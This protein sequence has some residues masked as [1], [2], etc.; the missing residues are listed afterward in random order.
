MP[1][2]GYWR[3]AA[4]RENAQKPELAPVTTGLGEIYQYVLR[5]EPGYEKKYSLA[6]LR[7]IQDW[8]VRRQILGTKGVADVS[9][10]GG[11]LKQYEVS[12]NPARLKAMPTLKWGNQRS[13]R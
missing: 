12:V 9:T 5:P 2:P 6:E 3:C 10:F 13:I 8:L 11:E 4:R 1:T 7:T